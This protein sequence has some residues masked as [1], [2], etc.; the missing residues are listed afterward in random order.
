MR[1]RS[2]SSLSI[3]V[4]AS[5]ATG[6]IT[7]AMAQ[8]PAPTAPAVA[9]AP[10]R[11]EAESATPTITRELQLTN[12]GA[13]TIRVQLSVVGLGH[14]LSG[15]P[16]FLD[17]APVQDVLHVAPGSLTLGPGEVATVTATGSFTP[18]R[19]GIDAAVVADVTPA[20][21]GELTPSRIAAL[22]L[23]R[24]PG[25]WTATATVAGAG[26]EP[27]AGPLTV[28]ADITNHGTVHVQ[29]SATAAVRQGARTL[30][31]IPL[32]SQVV[33][34]GF[35]R[36]LVG[37]WTPPANF[38]SDVTIDVRT[39]SP[40]AT[41]LGAASIRSGRVSGPSGT[42]EGLTARR[43]SGALVTGTVRNTGTEPF[44]PT[45]SVS[46]SEDGVERARTILVE[47]PVAPGA[48]ETFQWLAPVEDG[49][50]VFTAQ[51]QSGDTLLDETAFGARLAPPAFAPAGVE[52]TRPQRSIL[53]AIA[54]GLQLATMC[55]YVF[56]YLR[57]RRGAHSPGAR[58]AAA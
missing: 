57:G 4:A 37:S 48:T 18:A 31:S 53:I 26:I 33:L 47:T 52:P 13:T 12:R 6:I 56:V 1:S 51:L 46:A 19:P 55:A 24:G 27:G 14:D 34:P 39:S 45:V 5:I 58:T 9:L 2:S 36:R 17:P 15:S 29:P 41:G 11:I 10:A 49:A 42:L 35:T 38:T 20:Q 44:T 22:L 3:L 32:A 21:P 16:L 28:Y 23:L 54:V 43:Q 25:P 40:L 7:A 50:Y 8:T 30:A